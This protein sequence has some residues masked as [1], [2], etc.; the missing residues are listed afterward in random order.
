MF[1][2]AGITETA[3]LQPVD[4]SLA[5]HTESVWAVATGVVDVV[6]VAVTGSSDETAWVWGPAAGRPAGRTGVGVSLTGRRPTVGHPRRALAPSS[7][8]SQRPRAERLR[9][10]V[11]RIEF[12]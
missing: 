6:P 8:A 12:R 4:E 7:S 11:A 1:A 9:T 2:D 5:G 10:C 3:A